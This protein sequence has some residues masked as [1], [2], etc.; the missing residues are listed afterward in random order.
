MLFTCG[1]Y[2]ALPCGHVAAAEAV[3][4]ELVT[5]D[6]PNGPVTVLSTDYYD[7]SNKGYILSCND[8][9]L[10]DACT[11]FNDANLPFIFSSD[12]LTKIKLNSNRTRYY[13]TYGNYDYI[14]PQMFVN[15]WD[16]YLLVNF[17]TG[18][19]L[20]MQ[21]SPANAKYSCV[22]ATRFTDPL[23][24]LISSDP[25]CSYTDA[26]CDNICDECGELLPMEYWST[27]LEY[28]VTQGYNLTKN[29]P[30]RYFAVLYNNISP[31]L[32]TGE[33]EFEINSAG[34]VLLTKNPTLY[35]LFE[36][37]NGSFSLSLDDDVSKT[38][39]GLYLDPNQYICSDG[40]LRIMYAN[41]SVD[42]RYV[43]NPA[44]DPFGGGDTVGGGADR[45]QATRFDID[46]DTYE[47][48]GGLPADP[49]YG[50]GRVDVVVSPTAPPL[51]VPVS[52]TTSV[53]PSPDPVPVVTPTPD[54]SD[55]NSIII[56]NQIT[57]IGNDLAAL[58]EKVGE[59]ITDKIGDSI[60]G[61]FV[62]SETDIVAV[63]EKWTTL[64]SERF[65][66]VYES[67]TVLDGVFDAF[68]FDA[69]QPTFTFP[70]IELEFSGVP[71]VLGGWEVRL[72][73]EGFDFIVPIIKSIT[74]IAL[75]LV[76]LNAM[77]KKY[78]RLVHH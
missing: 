44:Y 73:P 47:P 39:D 74:D 40:E 19:V 64:F 33:T 75:T 12:G 54:P 8:A 10:I 69:V 31:V 13:F 62:P 26:N 34:D 27:Y 14:S 53:T 61:L 63:K 22:T 4:Y 46:L 65:G 72:I 30:A 17:D 3:N 49:E 7:S 24:E 55:P 9:S 36:W 25:S 15:T 76:F 67:T 28:L 43:Y 42:N 32:I 57:N 11:T 21:K 38:A 48:I 18:Y 35:S 56:Q 60:K 70:T 16:Y 23:L 66:A 68:V 41:H 37:E 20:L 51:A 59:K 78:E 52:P 71:F 58:P 77:R 6:T 29:S 1:V 2:S 5:L 50:S 45:E